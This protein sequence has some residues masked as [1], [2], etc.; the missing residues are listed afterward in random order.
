MRDSRILFSACVARSEIPLSLYELRDSHFV[1]MKIT[2]FWDPMPRRMVNTN[3]R[4]GGTS[5]SYRKGLFQ[6]SQQLSLNHQCVCTR[7]HGITSQKT[8]Y[9][10]IERFIIVHNLPNTFHEGVRPGNFAFRRVRKIAKSD[11][12]F[13]HVCPS[14]R[15]SVLVEKLGF[16]WSYFD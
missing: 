1:A 14:V 13:S 4:F 9:K 5:C 6:W 2:A 11:Y 10:H 8:F 16:L 7:S 15:L 3:R 12:Q